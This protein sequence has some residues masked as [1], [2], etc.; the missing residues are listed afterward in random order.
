MNGLIEFLTTEEMIVVYVLLGIAS[1]LGLIVYFLDKTH[2]KRR[3]RQ[4]TRE[5]RKIVDEVAPSNSGEIQQNVEPVLINKPEVKTNSVVAPVEV[6]SPVVE[7]E[8]ESVQTP[9]VDS[10]IE[11]VSAPVTTPPVV[12]VAP[13]VE[14]VA[15]VVENP[16][17]VD[18]IDYQNDVK[19]V[20]LDQ[21]EEKSNIVNEVN[22]NVEMLNEINEEANHQSFESDGLQYTSI[23]PDPSEAQ[24]ELMRLTEVLEKA[25]EETKNIDLTAFEEEQ[26]QNAIISL[27]ELMSRNKALY[28][29]GEL[30]KLE[31]EGN[32]PISIQDLEERMKAQKEVTNPVSAVEEPVIISTVSEERQMSLD[33]FQSVSIPSVEP[34]TP[35]VESVTP[36]VEEKPVYQEH[37][38][39]KSSPVISPVYGIEKPVVNSSSDIELENTANY[40]KLDEEIRKTNEFLM[41]LREL[42]KK[43]D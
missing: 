9:V 16:E 18:V 22:N 20:S 17:P 38:K 43:L 21:I 33:D 15:P 29:S 35:V 7:V 36:R 39:F 28:E 5:L 32:E 6:V 11:N 27:D 23:E 40:E 41:T 13:T 42:Q 10:V 3:Q 34:V 30:E 26:E 8:K 4:N 24:A 14:M 12:E 1:V 19:P 2:N 25:E 37:K 31:D